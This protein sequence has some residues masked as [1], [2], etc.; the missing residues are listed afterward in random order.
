VDAIVVPEPTTEAV[1]AFHRSAGGWKYLLPEDFI[2]EIHKRREIR[3]Q[4]V[5]L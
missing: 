5:D 4:P 2:G 3:R 1:E